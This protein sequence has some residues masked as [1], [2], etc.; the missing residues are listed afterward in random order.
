MRNITNR[1]R[2]AVLVHAKV[3]FIFN[4]SVANKL[5]H[6]LALK[7]RQDNTRQKQLLG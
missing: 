5:T 4:T 3:L 2:A 7:P 1:A 6:M